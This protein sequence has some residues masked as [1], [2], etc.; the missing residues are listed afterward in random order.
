MSSDNIEK[1]KKNQ[2]LIVRTRIQQNQHIDVTCETERVV[3]IISQQ[4]ETGLKAQ[5]K[6]CLFTP[7]KLNRLERKK[8][9]YGFEGPTILNIIY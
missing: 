1:V 2:D 9:E 7:G 3:N 5:K 4:E 8:K 6:E